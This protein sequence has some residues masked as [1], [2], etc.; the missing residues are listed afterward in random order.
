[1]KVNIIKPH[2]HYPLG[3]IDLPEARAKYL[4]SIKVAEE[5]K[6]KKEHVPAREKKE[7]TNPGTKKKK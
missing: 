6:E 2:H 3:E 7:I 4:I 1:M 5:V